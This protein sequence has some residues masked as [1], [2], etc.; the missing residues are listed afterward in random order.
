MK[1][2]VIKAGR[3]VV[4]DVPAPGVEPGSVLV[5][6]DHSCI[7]AGTEM[8]A[9]RQTGAPLWRRALAE[10]GKVWKALEMLAEK[11]L[12]RTRDAIEGKLQAG[13]PTGYSAAGV[14]LEVGR[15]VDDILPGDRVACAGASFAHHAE[16]ISV[17][18]NLTVPVPGNLDF[19]TAAT[20]TLGAI[21]LQGVR[22]AAPTL[23]E[24][25]AV[26]GLGVL[27]QLT[28]QILRADGCRV[29]GLDLDRARLALAGELGLDFALHPED[30]D[31]LEAAARLTGGVGVDGVIITASSRSDAV[32]A[33]AFRLCRRKGRVVLVG[34]VGL[35]LD[36]ADIYRKELDFLVS[37]SYGPG[38]YDR[39][40]E[41][42]GL[43][44]P[45][46]YVRWTENRNLA[47][48]L[49]LCA[50]GKVRVGPLTAAV[51]PVEEAARAYEA[52]GRGGSAA[53]IV[54]LSYA[55]A[56]EKPARRLPNPRA[57]PGG[58]GAVRLAVVGAGGF[59]RGTHLPN[60]KALPDLYRLR[61]V[62][63]RTGHAAA[64]VAGQYGA[65]YSSTD[66]AEVLRDPEV[67]AVL[68][69]TRHDKHAGMVLAALNAGKSV[70]VEKP[71][72]L[73]AGELE[74][75]EAFYAGAG[76]GA[77]APLLMTGF[78]RRFSPHARIVRQLSRGRREPM[79]LCCRVNAGRIPLDHWVHSPEG[80]GRNLGEACHFYDLFTFLADS[81]VKSVQA[82]SA[83][84]GEGYY[85][86]RDN[87]AAAVTFEDGSLA[88]L[89]YTAMGNRDLPKERVE[90]F[91]EGKAAVIDDYRRLEVRGL[92]GD[93]PE[94][95]DKG[96]LE[97]LRAF[98]RAVGRG[99]EW[100]IPL[101]QQLQAAR[102]AL[103][104]EEAL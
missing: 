73:T 93:W 28:V 47:E 77:S 72:A 86:R 58:G 34:D 32:V 25:F 98:A 29:I 80:G 71:L 5:R 46:A 37:T 99:G 6:V 95:A 79:V 65:D 60:L 68:I 15:G 39:R 91:W 20:V 94:A 61:A 18:R 88:S 83:V 82:A 50:E 74:T 49:R 38:R 4:E 53:P 100:P 57:L 75:I 19:K 44:Y 11:G 103:A 59:A 1:Q 55:A 64:A 43:D 78:N 16:I 90:C 36:R 69:C 2:V 45:V 12:A 7:S 92:K 48:Y 62:V 70:L 97:E 63:S 8:S 22:R 3:A 40:Y 66:F 24:T 54:L 96:H 87:F 35:A 26:I 76:E 31:A 17:P 84:P 56:A 41:E 85:T 21:A 10:P 27:G 42:E 101:W 104:V 81:R 13:E 102:I 67:D 52:I 33:S 23:G 14:V 30:G 51:Y 89:V 9:V